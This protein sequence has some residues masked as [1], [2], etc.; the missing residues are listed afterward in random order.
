[1]NKVL[2]KKIMPAGSMITDAGAVW[3][4]RHGH[5]G[6][7]MVHKL[8]K[9]AMDAGFVAGNYD[10]VGTPCGTTVGHTHQMKHPD[11]WLLTSSILM[12]VTAY[13][14]SYSA[15]IKK[16]PAEQVQTS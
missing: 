11:G 3:H 9:R 5:A 6:A 14:N 10:H 4:K 2:F 15:S 1:M 8:R 12:G 13:D 7:T 16:I